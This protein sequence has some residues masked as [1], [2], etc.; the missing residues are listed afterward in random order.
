MTCSW[1]HGSSVAP[2]LVRRSLDALY[3]SFT[4]IVL[5]TLLMLIIIIII[6]IINVD[7]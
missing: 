3:V 6:I 7:V 1:K 2:Q 5:P 4:T